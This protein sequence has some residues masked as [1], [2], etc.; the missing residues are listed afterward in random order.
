MKTG[1]TKRVYAL[2]D[3]RCRIVSGLLVQEENGVINADGMLQ[4]GS[5]W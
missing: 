5:I 3:K 4:F 2:A 1:G